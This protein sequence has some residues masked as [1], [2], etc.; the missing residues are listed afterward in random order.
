MFMLYT[1]GK[2]ENEYER[3][4]KSIVSGQ[5]ERRREKKTKEKNMSRYVCIDVNYN[6]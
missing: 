3:R 2:P 4:L 1:D 6:I 5:E